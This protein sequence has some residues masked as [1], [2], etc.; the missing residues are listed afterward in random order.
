MFRPNTPHPLTS[1]CVTVIIGLMLGLPT[2]NFI[3]RGLW[4][5]A[6]QAVAQAQNAHQSQ[7]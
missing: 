4:S 2:L 7:D 3:G 1:I 5:M 6:S